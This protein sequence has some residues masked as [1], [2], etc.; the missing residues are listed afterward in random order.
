M[1]V[2]VCPTVLQPLEHWESGIGVL[3]PPLLEAFLSPKRV[4]ESCDCV[5]SVRWD[6]ANVAQCCEFDGGIW[7]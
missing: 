2:P 1:G 3:F 6:P 4:P 5:N 7:G